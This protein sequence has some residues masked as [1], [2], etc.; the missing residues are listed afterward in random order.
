MSPEELALMEEAPRTG[1]SFGSYGEDP[2]TTENV[3]W[4]SP[5][6]MTR[7]VSRPM[8]LLDVAL[9]ARTR[10]NVTQRPRER[11]ERRTA[12]T[13]GSRGDPAPGDESDLARPPLSAEVRDFLRREVD[14]RRR[15]QLVAE[16]HH[17]QAVPS[18][19]WA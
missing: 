11:R 15:A 3:V 16:R 7:P 6:R 19:G 5:R 12:R 1:R 8:P 13:V 2:P 10:P 18:G 17:L 9:Q 14:R 4:S